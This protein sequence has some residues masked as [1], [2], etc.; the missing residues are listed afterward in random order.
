MNHSYQPLGKF[1]LMSVFTRVMMLNMVITISRT[2]IIVFSKSNNI[3][4]TLNLLTTNLM[5]NIVVYSH[6]H[7]AK[8]G[9]FT[10]ACKFFNYLYSLSIVFL[11]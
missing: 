6:E 8:V 3:I 7:I 2:D 10:M 11:I 4:F 1:H 5:N 9:D